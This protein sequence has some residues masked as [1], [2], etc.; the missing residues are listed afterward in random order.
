MIKDVIIILYSYSSNL[1]DI[2]YKTSL[3]N[4]FLEGAWAD[5]NTTLTKIQTKNHGYL[6]NHGNN[7][8]TIVLLH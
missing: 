4:T 6:L 2:C 3:Y 5:N 1:A 8:F 7:K